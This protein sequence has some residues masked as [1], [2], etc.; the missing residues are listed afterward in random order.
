MNMNIEKEYKIL[1][2]RAEFETL[3]K[4][5]P[6]A[7][8]HKQVNTYYDTKEQQIRMH[9]GA[10]RIREVQGQFLFTLKM[11]ADQG[12]M[13]YEK[14]VDRN[15]QG[16]FADSEIQTLL[17]SFDIDQEVFPITSLTTYRAVI[18]TGDAELCF[19]YNEYGTKKDYEIEYEYKRAHDGETAFSHI[20]ALANLKY[21]KNCTSKIQRAL[22]ALDR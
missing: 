1:V 16:V 3:L 10:M 4:Q 7:V 22:D 13:E 6:Q 18:D 2:T 19:D 14:I 5:Y 15:D 21:K 8:F 11:H 17:S 20:L 9:H 12:L